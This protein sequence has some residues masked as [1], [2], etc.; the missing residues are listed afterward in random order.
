LTRSTKGRKGPS[1]SL[2]EALLSSVGKR[3]STV[4]RVCVGLHWTAVRSAKV[5]MAHTYKSARKVELEQ[6]GALEGTSAAAMAHRILSWEP[7]EASLGTAAFNSLIEPIGEKGGI[8]DVIMEKAKGKTVTVIGRF[9]FNDEVREVAK[10]AHFLEMEP[11]RGELPSHAAEHVIPISDV[12]VITATALINHTL[13]RLLELASGNY[14]IVLGPST[15]M[16]RVLFDFGA[17]VLAGV[18]VTEPEALF[19]SVS[20]G[21]KSFKKLSGIEPVCL[22]RK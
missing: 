16:N 2:E 3:D 20:Q 14:A 8:N 18:R 1:L 13:Q 11:E 9:P 19:K 4:E 17:D 15:P 12:T 5:G 21:V 10:K 7:L 6:S 22:F